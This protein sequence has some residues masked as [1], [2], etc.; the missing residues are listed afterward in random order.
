MAALPEPATWERVRE[1]FWYVRVP[2][3]ARSWIPFEVEVGERSVKVT[4]HVIIEPDEHRAEV[5]GLL[6]RHNH[7]AGGAYFS[8]DGK[9]GVICLVNR[10][11]LDGFDE[12]RL[13]EIVGAM[14]EQTENTFRTII[15]MGFASRLKKG[16]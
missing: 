4:S 2:G 7:R 5:Y 15:Q 12:G 14:V 9:E 16:G 3:T 10:I 6:L 1:N 13:D 8:L 11:G